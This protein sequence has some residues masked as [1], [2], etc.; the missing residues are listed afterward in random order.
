MVRLTGMPPLIGPQ[1]RSATWKRSLTASHGVAEEQTHT[2]NSKHA[3]GNNQPHVKITAI[4]IC[5]HVYL[6]LLGSLI[7]WR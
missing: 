3:T 5:I 6:S 7:A 2:H 1:S 4:R